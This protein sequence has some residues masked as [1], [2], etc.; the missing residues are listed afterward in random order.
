MDFTNRL[1][2]GY[3]LIDESGMK[4]DK[5]FDYWINLSLEFNKKAKVSKKTKK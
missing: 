2:I 3:V 5:E 4:T 1:M